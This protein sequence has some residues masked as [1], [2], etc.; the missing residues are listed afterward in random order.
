MS[1]PL[2]Q[3]PNGVPMGAWLAQSRQ[4]LHTVTIYYGP[5]RYYNLGSRRFRHRRCPRPVGLR[6]RHGALVLDLPAPTEATVLH[7][8]QVGP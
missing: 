2:G 5:G 6:L 3:T 4:G 8:P 7:Q 1:N